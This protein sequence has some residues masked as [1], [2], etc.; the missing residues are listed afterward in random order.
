MCA[1]DG[2][3]ALLHEMFSLR[4][5]SVS[6]FDSSVSGSSHIDDLL[7]DGNMPAR[8]FP[9]LDFLVAVAKFHPF[10]ATGEM[11]DAQELLAWLIDALHEDLNRVCQADP[12][13]DAADA[14]QSLL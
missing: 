6:T 1:Y 13:R 11:H 4:S 5:A 7:R 3:A 14:C 10:L 8:P 12:A 9:P 2:F